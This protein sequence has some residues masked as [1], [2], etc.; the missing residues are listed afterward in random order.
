MAW[1]LPVPGKAPAMGASGQDREP[2]ARARR[3]GRRRRAGGDRGRKA[4]GTCH[5]I[6][7]RAGPEFLGVPKLF[8]VVR[9]M[10]YVGKF[11]SDMRWRIRRIAVRILVKWQLGGRKARWTGVAG[12]ALPWAEAVLVV[13]N[14][15]PGS[16][17]LVSQLNFQRRSVRA[18][19]NQ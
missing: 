10:R 2:P 18:G 6:A 19:K 11:S 3:P 5:F 14:K 15:C 1:L 4:S 12:R 9:M 8:A 16:H 17:P 7:V 13:D